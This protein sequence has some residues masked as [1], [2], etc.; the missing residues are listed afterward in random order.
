MLVAAFIFVLSCVAF[1]RFAVFQWRAGLVRVVCAA[2]AVENAPPSDL[3]LNLLRNK[4]L[5]TWQLFRNCAR[6]WNRLLRT[7][8]A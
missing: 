7:S 1:V 5:G 2:T 6:I 4:T 8:A 3:A